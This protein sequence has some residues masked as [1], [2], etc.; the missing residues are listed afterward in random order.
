MPCAGVTPGRID[1]EIIAGFGDSLTLGLAAQVRKPPSRQSKLVT[2][3]HN[4]GGSIVMR[5]VRKHKCF[6]AGREPGRP[7]RFPT[8]TRE[9]KKEQ[10]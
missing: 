1:S 6:L 8:C 2:R 3:L 10:L 5:F 9:R 7:N 4:P